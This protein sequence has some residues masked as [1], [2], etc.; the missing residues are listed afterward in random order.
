MDNRIEVIDNNLIEL[1]DRCSIDTQIDLIIHRHKGNRQS[2]NT[3]VFDSVALLTEADTNQNTL[4]NKGFFKRLV[5]SITG[6][7][8]K[9]E[10]KIN[11]NRAQAQYLA[12]QTIQRLAEQNLLTFDLIA[13]VNNKLNFNLQALNSEVQNIYNGLNRF[14]TMYKGHLV[15]IESRLDTLERNVNL[16]TWTTS[17]E[18]Q[19]Y[20]GIHYTDL[21]DNQK[22]ICLI[23][24][25]YEI[26]KGDWR[27]SDLLLLK[28]AL[29]EL[30]LVPNDKINYLETLIYIY[31]NKM[32]MSKY[33]GGSNQLILQDTS[34]S[35]VALE[36]LRKL[37]LL[38][39]EEAY[40]VLACK[41]YTNNEAS[42]GSIRNDLLDL[43]FKEVKG[44]DVDKEVSRY[45][46]ILDLL[47]NLKESEH[48]NLIVNRQIYN[49]DQFALVDITKNYAN[50]LFSKG[51]I[52]LEDKNYEEAYKLFSESVDLGNTDAIYEL[53]ECY[54]WGRGIEVNYE[55]AI[56]LIEK[57]IAE[58]NNDCYFLM[59]RAVHDGNGVEQSTERAKE[60]YTKAI[61]LAN[62][63]VV[64]KAQCNL[65][66]I[67]WD[68]AD[69]GSD[70]SSIIG[71]YE[72]AINHG[73]YIAMYNLAKN[74]DTA[75]KIEQDYY[76]AYCYYRMAAR[77]NYAPAQAEVAW[78]YE[79]GF[80]VPQNYKKAI[81][82][83]ELA[84]AGGHLIATNNLGYIY[85]NGLGVATN[86]EKGF[87]LYMKAYDQRT[88]DKEIG[89]LMSNIAECYEYG[90][91][92]QQDYKLALD[93]Y[94]KAQV[95]GESSA[96]EG[97]NR[98]SHYR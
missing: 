28:S 13:S 42:I 76:S 85:I 80:G 43:Y 75:N 7:N 23:R 54:Y 53:S 27:T 34:D 11:E 19:L 40:Q 92:V 30:N 25:F 73:S 86:Q 60:Y 83:Y 1:E 56:E 4:N 49:E 29:N 24:D 9:L 95:A 87:A 48:R 47:F 31:D 38:E 5:G 6:S 33:L 94:R 2:I 16:L 18:Y 59:G 65:A 79:K 90:R 32:V 93:W 97:I 41:A 64:G 55:K 68:E 88:S 82:W 44:I 70:M 96:Q 62:T 21:D 35:L 39:N 22:M 58:D 3:L 45:D 91:G 71:L 61:E 17:I 77:L 66:N 81:Y 20:D 69:D 89:P 36:L 67:L 15:Q 51:R 10:S 14:L 37:D 84:S 74:Y 78:M 26:T 63:V 98:L 8:R 52:A 72:S 46:F 50:E 12:Q 57:G